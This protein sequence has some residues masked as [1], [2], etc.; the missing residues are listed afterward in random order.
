M[1]LALGCANPDAMLARMPFRVYREWHAYYQVEPFGEKR[2]DFRSAIVAATIANTMG[3]RKGQP[4]F[5]VEKFMPQFEPREI[6]KKTPDQLFDKLKILNR[7][8]GGAFVDE[9]KHGSDD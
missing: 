2:A 4:A 6:V 1:A 5:R 7:L 9:R 8:M 3:R